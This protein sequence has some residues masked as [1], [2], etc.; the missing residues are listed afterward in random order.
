MNVRAHVSMLFHLDKCI[1]CHTCSVACKN[2]WTDRK[3]T[4][5]MWWNNVETRPGTGYPTGWE[6]QERF[7]GGWER[8]GNQLELKLHSRPK[9]LANLFFNPALPELDDYYEP[10]TFR[11]QD[12]FNSP[13]GN[14][15]PVARPVSMI[16]G[17][18]MNI[19]AGP[20][21][22]DDLGG[23]NLYAQNDPSWD[24]VDEGIL[25]QMGEIE[26]V[27]FN[28][29]PRICNHC[30]N[31]SCVA[32]CPS[33]AIYKRAEDG[34]VLVN[35]NKCK[36]WRMCVAACPYKKVFYNWA[37][38]K[39]EKC[40]LCFP[41]METGQAPAC[42][43]SCVGRIRYM[44]VLLYDADKIPAAAMVDDEHLVSSHLDV[45][46]DPFDP[47]VIAAA[48]AGGLDEGWI[49]AA[50]ESPVYKFVKVWGLALPLHP[51]YR[52]MAMMYYIP[53][54]S[55]I[56]STIERGLVRLEL[57]PEKVDFELFNHLEKA[58]LPLKYLANLFAAGNVEVIK[59]ILQKMLA[60]RIL[61]RKQS[62]EGAVD[63]A[64]LKLLESVRLDLETAEAIYRLTTLPTLEQRFVLPPYH[65]EM[66][67]EAWN[68][69]LAHKGEVGVGTIELP[70]RG[71]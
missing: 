15:Q 46:L 42:A 66:A 43:H 49:K 44:G 7:Q 56:V 58:R 31:P 4:E 24:G 55:P 8:R 62:V 47:E 59:P 5:Y 26:R 45:I 35:E 71:N 41:R 33:G 40:I 29:L 28:Y 67:T 68:D 18:P 53:P 39:S 10:F 21:W 50:Q 25:A 51:E 23:S 9:G 32:A 54:L 65:R 11:Y 70:V 19:E 36:G 27:V 3:G 14:D 13:E 12:L 6:D 69:P 16:T 61:K 34:V 38:G 57:P 64:T 1:G 52:T 48:K 60:V 2:L 63:T 22:D 17:E 37:T 30:L 20:N